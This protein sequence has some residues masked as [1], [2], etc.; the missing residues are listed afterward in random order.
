MA[1]L[2]LVTLLLGAA[3]EMWIARELRASGDADLFFR[4]LVVIGAARS[5]GLSIFRARWIPAPA[6]LAPRALLAAERSASA[7]LAGAALL[8]LLA[9]VGPAA[10]AEPS[11]WA[12][13]ASVLVALVG[14]ALRALSERAGQLRRGFALDWALPLGAIAGAVLLPGGALGPSLG[15]L[16][17][18]SVA[19]LG[20]AAIAW[21]QGALGGRAAAPARSPV[22]DPAALPSAPAPARTR[23]L[24]I[25]AVTY[26][27]LGLVE[28]ALS[29]LFAVG[30][31][32][33]INYAF[34]F[35]NAA[36]MVPS[37]A[38]T[39]LALRLAAEAPADARRRLRRWAALGGL[40]I[41]A[42][43]A[44]IGLALRA[45]PLA[46]LVDAAIGWDVSGETGAIVLLSAPFAGLRL[47]NTIGRQA[48][49]AADPAPLLRW[50]LA[51]LAGRA[52]ILGV[53]AR[54]IGVLASPLALTFAELV[55]LGAWARPPAPRRPPLLHP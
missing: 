39:V 16:A 37:A 26:V 20:Q 19:A 43:V 21:D 1:G 9:V 29:H 3:R 34:L 28:A 44:A 42:A 12:A 30:G 33:L 46:R 25:D 55:Q 52:L 13:G 8:A 4:G 15:I 35:V 18:V 40:A 38:A 47:A 31:F 50:N 45:S 32:A 54:A 41:A 14:A 48:Q 24:V 17:G 5:V 6:Q 23:A 36:L 51:G 49:V 7:L 22:A 53:G 27:N 11:V 2:S 10:W